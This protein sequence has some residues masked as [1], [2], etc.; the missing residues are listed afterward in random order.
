MSRTSYIF[1]NHGENKLHFPVSWREP[2]SIF[3]Y[4]GENKL[5]FSSIM[6]RTSYIFQYHGESKLHFPVSWREQV[7]FSSIM[8]RA[9][10]IF[11]YHGE[12]KFHFPV[13]WREQVTFSSIMARTSYTSPWT[14]FELTTLVVIGT[15]CAGSCKSNYHTITNRVDGVMVSVFASSAIDHGFEQH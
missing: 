4:H 5:A 3:Q 2:V 9:S 12:S 1:Q 13:S 15:D 10:Y 6:T 8:A 11:Q 7:T 14:V